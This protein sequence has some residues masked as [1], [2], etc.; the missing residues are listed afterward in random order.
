LSASDVT[1]VLAILAAAYPSVEV[2][3]STLVVYETMLADVSPEELQAVVLEHIARSRWFPTVAELRGAIAERRMSLPS[4][5]E[6]LASVS[7]AL[8]KNTAAEMHG[9]VF[10]AVERCGGLWEAK[11]STTPQR[12]R[13]QF[14]DAYRELRTEAVAEA[15]LEGVRENLLTPATRRVLLEGRR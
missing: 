10:E 8:A 15:N 5:A 14:L 1:A 2:S 3:E 11:R 6:A 7:K 9:L 13:Q 12:W 4:A